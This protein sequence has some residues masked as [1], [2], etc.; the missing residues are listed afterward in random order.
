MQLT[1]GQK[2]KSS[3][4]GERIQPG[5]P[6]VGDVATDAKDSGVGLDLMLSRGRPVA[7][8]GTFQETEVA[9]APRI[10]DTHEGGKAAHPRNC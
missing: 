2:L 10:V 8:V 5:P 3:A 9:Y 4:H 1:A 7:R 6:P